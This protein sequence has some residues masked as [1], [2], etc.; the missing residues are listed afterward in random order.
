MLKSHIVAALRALRRQPGYSALNIV[1][2]AVGFVAAFLILS[3][4]RDEVRTDQ[5][6]SDRL[7]QVVQHA[8][9]DDGETIGTLNVAP[10]PLAAALEA[11]VP[12]VE[13]AMMMRYEGE[14]VVAAGERTFWAEGFWT[15][16]PF[17]EMFAF[18]LV[19]GDPAS[20][21]AAPDGIV[22]T[23][24]MVAKLFGAETTP[25]AAMGRAVRFN[26]HE[27]RVTAVAADPPE[28]S[29]MAFEWV[30]PASEFYAR[31]AWVE[32]WENNAMQLFVTL[33]PGAD[34]AAFNRTMSDI[35][36]AR[37]DIE[38]AT[39][40][41]QRFSERYLRSD[42]ENGVLVG[43]RIDQVRTFALIAVLLLALA[44]INFT[45]LATARAT[46]RADE[47]G[48]RKTMG[49]T[50][51]AL[52]RQFLGESVLTAF[53]AF[54]VAVGLFVLLLGPFGTAFGTTLSLGSLSPWVWLG[55]AGIALGVGLVAGLYP[56][57]VLS[58]FSPVRVLR[59]GRRGGLALRRG[60][61]VFQFAASVVLIIGTLVVTAQLGFLQDRDIGL[62]REE[63]VTVPLRGGAKSGYPAFRQA[64]LD[65]PAVTHVGSTN[66]MPLWIGSST[67]SVDWPGK[68]PESLP[69]F[70]HMIVD[71]DAIEALGMEMASGRDFSADVVADSSNYIVNEAAARLMGLDAPVGETIAMWEEPGEIVGVVKDFHMSPATSATEPTIL[72]LGTPEETLWAMAFV[73]FASGQAE[74]GLARLVT[75][76]ETFSADYPLE[77]TFLDEAYDEMY[78]SHIRLGTMAALF[79]VLAALIAALGLVGLAAY[80]AEQRRK[81]VGVRRVLGATVASVVGLLSRDFLLWVAAACAVAIPVAAVLAER[82]LDGF[83]YRVDVGVGPFAVASLAALGLALLAAGTQALR[84]ATAD[85]VHALRSE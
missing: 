15:D 23:E 25:E 75:V 38:G 50:R 58:R 70:Y 42:Y 73:R 27:A 29:S 71:T 78:Q 57:V 62:D 53:V 67:G 61:V 72:R 8:S 26:D 56:A 82:W 45:N 12:G 19:A 40:S 7:F 31:N 13:R 34:V 5:M 18:P 20:A 64:L 65:D 51:G 11:D 49:A 55:F 28:A 69:S 37:G 3:M 14:Q 63:V 17:F 4:V 36:A 47:I 85:P 54:V 44:C 80:A 16:A 52:M 46:R 83:A 76:S 81:E 21:L 22:L 79:A 1:G 43:G 48:V 10:Q 66:S 77:Y 24:A 32:S 2:L 74:A 9:F 59:G 35:L 39:A 68:A 84:A 30:V 41:A 6:H 60:L 33:R